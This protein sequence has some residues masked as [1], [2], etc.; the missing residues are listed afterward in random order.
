MS[1]IAFEDYSVADRDHM[2][3]YLARFRKFG[4]HATCV[5][6][7]KCEACMVPAYPGYEFTC[8]ERQRRLDHGGIATSITEASSSALPLNKKRR[9]GWGWKK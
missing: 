2:D 1:K 5:G 6:C 7:P 8:G 4:P 9:G 3:A